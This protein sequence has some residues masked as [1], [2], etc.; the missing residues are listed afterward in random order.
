MYLFILTSILTVSGAEM[1][2]LS[3][4]LPI[5]GTHYSIIVSFLVLFSASSEYRSRHFVLIFLKTVYAAQS[6]T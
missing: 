1:S 2:S 4:L 6:K 3:V 5:T